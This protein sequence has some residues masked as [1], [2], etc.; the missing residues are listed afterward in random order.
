MNYEVN[1]IRKDST[2]YSNRFN[3]LFLINIDYTEINIL[4]YTKN[5]R[6][7]DSLL[8]NILHSF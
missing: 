4:K 2:L 8:M 5:F 1:L 7:Y 6:K 3:S